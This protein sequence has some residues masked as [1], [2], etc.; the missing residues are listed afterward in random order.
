MPDYQN[1]ILKQP[2]QKV[3]VERNIGVDVLS[4]YP[5]SDS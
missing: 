3:D 5:G 2:Q 1:Q 4:E